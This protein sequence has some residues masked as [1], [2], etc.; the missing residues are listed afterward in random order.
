LVRGSS[1]DGT[2][3]GYAFG[4]AGWLASARTVGD[5]SIIYR[6]AMRVEAKDPREMDPALIGFD[7]SSW[8]PTLWELIPYSFLIDYFSNIG[9]VIRGWSQM[10]VRLAWC[11]RTSRKTFTKTAWSSPS[12]VFPAQAFSAAKFVCTR[13]RVSRASYSGTTVPKP[14]LE[15][16]SLG[17]LKWL[18]IAALIANR[19]ADRN[20]VYGN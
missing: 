7:L 5:V 20:W 18:N 13:V 2:T 12:G 11:N 8:A 19:R 3:T 6:G 16:P 10:G 4:A 14:I 17:S 1:V 15:I 9:D